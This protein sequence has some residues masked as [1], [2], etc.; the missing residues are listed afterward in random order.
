MKTGSLMLVSAFCLAQSLILAEE[1]VFTAIKVIAPP[2]IDGKLDDQP[3]E[4]ASEYGGFG[5]SNKKTAKEQTSARILYD[6]KG[7]YFGLKCIE[8]KMDRIS[9]SFASRGNCLWGN[10]CAVI[11]LDPHPHDEIYYQFAVNPLGAQ[12]N[13]RFHERPGG[14]YSHAW[15]SYNLWD[16]EWEARCS[17]EKNAWMV[18]AA[19]PYSV[20]EINSKVGAEWRVGFGRIEKPHG[21]SSH[22][23]ALCSWDKPETFGR[24][25]G[26]KAD[27]GRYVYAVETL[28]AK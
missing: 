6:E 15:A 13:L 22:L 17:M 24:L 12:C 2:V 14:A 16:C 5:L 1:G 26:I 23:P 20:L 4:K 3:W 18:E 11:F 9:A 7:I 8:F 19:I 28:F 21:E 27:F 10:D 25:R